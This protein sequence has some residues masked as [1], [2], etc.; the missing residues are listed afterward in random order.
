MGQGV[1]GLRGVASLRT[2]ASSSCAV[3]ELGGYATFFN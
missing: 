3:A 2:R 1:D